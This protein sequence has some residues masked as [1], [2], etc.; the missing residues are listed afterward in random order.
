MIIFQC[1]S[2]VPLI[3]THSVTSYDRNSRDCTIKV[4]YRDRWNYR[5]RA[6][7]TG[8]ASPPRAYAS[9]RECISSLH[10]CV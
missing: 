9:G 7:L 8:D 1:G 5:D 2:H 3:V 4:I 10:N 6:R